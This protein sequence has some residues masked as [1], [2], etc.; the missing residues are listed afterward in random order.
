MAGA[1][2]EQEGE[3]SGINVTPFVDVVLVLLI[4]LMVTSTQIVRA[5]LAVELPKAASG[6]DAVPSTLN[7][8]ILADGQL[9]IDG[10]PTDVEGVAALCDRR[11]RRI[12]R[13]RPSSPPTK[14]SRTKGH[15][16]HRRR[17]D[18]WGDELRAEHRARGTTRG[19]TWSDT[20]TRLGAQKND[21]H[22]DSQRVARDAPG[23]ER[24]SNGGSAP[25]R[26]TASRPMAL[27]DRPRGRR[28]FRDRRGLLW[29]EPRF[30]DVRAPVI[31]RRT[32]EHPDRRT[33]TGA[34]AS[35]AA[36]RARRGAEPTAPPKQPILRLPPK[37]R[38]SA[39]LRLLRIR[40]IGKSH[41]RRRSRLRVAS[42]ASTSSR[43]WRAGKVRASRSAT[44]AWAGPK[45]PRR[46]RRIS[47]TFQRTRRRSVD[48][49]ALPRAF[50]RQPAERGS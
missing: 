2:D 45:G 3:I 7:V 40:S 38:W 32:G 36:S 33:R 1:I 23:E 24:R 11:G 43:R 49:I 17:E 48:K 37:R 41:R 9:L 21:V 4:I 46:I 30:L 39:S 10:S 47:E 18:K 50:R 16:D 25:G 22:G 29:R 28:P 8:T 15:R 27:V 12:P 34:R 26:A 6:G 44:R 42:S 13:F 14:V 5:Q 35:S 20:I 31:V 19:L